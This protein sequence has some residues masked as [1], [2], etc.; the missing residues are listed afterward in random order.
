VPDSHEKL[1]GSSRL[2]PTG[3]RRVRNVDP[4]SHLEVTIGLKAPRLPATYLLPNKALSPKEFARRYG[5]SPR[6]IRKVKNVLEAFGLCVEGIGPTGRSLRVSGTARAMESAFKAGLGIYR[7][8]AQGEFRGRAGH[9]QVPAHIAGLVTAVLGL[10]QRRVACR[11]TDNPM[12]QNAIQPLSPANLEARY[13]FPEAGRSRQSIGIAEFGSGLL[14]PAYFPGL[15]SAFCKAQGRCVPQIKTVPINLT[16]L[17]TRQFNKL[18]RRAAA[19]VLVETG[20]VMMDVEIVAALCSAAKISVY[21]ASWDQKGWI[22]LLERVIG[23]RPVTLSI[24][25]G[26]AED[27]PDWEAAAVQAINDALQAAAM[28]GITVCV[29]S[30]DDGSGCRMPDTLAHVEFPSS[31]PFVLSVGGTMVES[32]GEQAEVSWWQSPGRRTTRGL[33]GASGGGVSTLF[34]RPAWQRARVRSL[35]SKAIV[36]RIVPD[37][38]ALAGPPFYTLMGNGGPTANGGT[39]AAAPLWASLIARV[40]AALPKK[41][42]RCFLSPVLYGMDRWGSAVGSSACMETGGHSNASHPRPGIGYRTRK[43]YDAVTGWGVPNGLALLEALKTT[44][45]MSV[46]RPR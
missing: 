10:D 40:N 36:G 8:S 7:S 43:G 29:S 6:D 12:S 5:A 13:K 16:P 46:T 34:R 39:S 37:V 3:A 38:A 20:E 31:S 45:R 11:K 4:S 21:Y 44:R 19:A 28:V 14:P 24:S 32:L 1:E 26:L 9:L 35:N 18:S 15:V 22:D 41:K 33:S 2:R 42:R 25:Y 23:A 27:S 30:G 17:T